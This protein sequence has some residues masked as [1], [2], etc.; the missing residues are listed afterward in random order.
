[1]KTGWNP[2]EWETLGQQLRCCDDSAVGAQEGHHTESTG[3][4]LRE[5]RR[6][7]EQLC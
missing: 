3:L 1:M 6:V 7:E 5:Q 4:E 2:G